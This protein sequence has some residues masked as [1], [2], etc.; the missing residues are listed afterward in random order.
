MSLLADVSNEVLEVAP[1][2]LG[3]GYSK[4]MYGR[5]YRKRSAGNMIF[6][7]GKR[8]AYSLAIHYGRGLRFVNRRI[9][10]TEI[11]R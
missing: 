11:P 10:G 7:P 5:W 8:R 9:Q 3:A 1:G 4:S 6:S 2:T